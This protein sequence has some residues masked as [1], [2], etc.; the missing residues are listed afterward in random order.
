MKLLVI[1]LSVMTW[2][3][4]SKNT[5]TLAEGGTKPND[6]EVSYANTYNKG[7][8]RAGDEAVLT[9]SNMGGITVERVSLAMRANAKS[10]A[11]TIEVACNNTQLAEKSV[12]WQSV[13]EDVEV[14]RGQQHDVDKLEIKVTGVQ[15]SVYIDAFTI[16]YTPHAPMSVVLMRGDTPI[17]T[18]MEEQ[19]MSGVMLPWLEDEDHWRF[20]GW[21]NT[22]FWTIYEEPTYHRANKR[23]NPANDT[24]W[25]VYQWEEVNTSERAFEEA[26]TS[27]VYMY[28]N[29][30]TNIALTGVP[31]N[32]KMGRAE[33]NVYDDNQHY[34]ITFIGTD[35]A[36]LTH[37][38]T[39]TPIGYSGTQVAAKAS[40]WKVYYEGD[41]TLFWTT[42]AGKNYVLWL[43]IAHAGNY[44]DLY[45][46]LFQADPG[47]SPMGLLG[48][49]M[50]TELYAFTCHP[51]AMVGME[52][53]QDSETSYQKILHNGQVLILR[54]GETYTLTGVKVERVKE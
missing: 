54:Q 47:N 1:I 14:F 34:Q 28:V 50:P 46:G 22:A 42:I 31:V 17:D 2:A 21:S 43:D 20:R 33:A 12:S 11:G 52:S 10:G 49:M 27:G 5:V 13:S 37:V 35:T 29:R 36:Y 18:L 23:Y 24:L 6:I 15:S 51:E 44:E 3:V 32:G 8:V 16:E 39:G 30:A 40:P 19:G 25:A 9:L 38:P 7:Q 4:E 53:V 26:G 48:T 41:Q 45:A